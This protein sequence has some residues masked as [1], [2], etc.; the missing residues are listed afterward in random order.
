MLNLAIGGLVKICGLR[1]VDAARAATLAGA[2]ALGFILAE[3]RR[4]VTPSFIRETHRAI[5]AECEKPP[6]FVGATVNADAR[7][8][9]QIAVEAE[10]DYIQLSGDESPD[11]L[12]DIDMPVIKA[13]HVAPGADLDSLDRLVDPWFDHPRA[14]V[15]ILIE[16]KLPGAYGGTGRQADWTLAAHLAARYPALLAG[17]LK[18]GNVAEGIQAVMPRGV[19]VSGGVEIAGEKDHAL[20]EA[21]I[22]RARQEF[23]LNTDD[24]QDS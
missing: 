23:A 22:A 14:A 6:A 21:F 24:V 2:D 3:S 7:G 10:L 16:P 11:I 9:E 1:S 19:D 12:D 4:Q 18:P 13:I 20:I 17:G 15:A 8:I 5:V